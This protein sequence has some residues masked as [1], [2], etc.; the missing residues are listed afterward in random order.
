[1]NL[2]FMLAA[3]AA[4]NRPI[5]IGMIG[6]GKFGTMFLS[7]V[8]STVGMHLTGLADLMPDRA[9]ERMEIAGFALERCEASSLDDAL[10][11]GATYV[12]D[13]Q[14]A[15][16]NH[17][18]IEVIIEATGDPANG[19]RIANA[20]IDAGK[21]IVMVNVE[22]DALA[23]PLLARRAR[24]AGVVYSL[25]WGDQPAL[26]CEHIDWARTCGF[27]VVAAGKGTRYHP[28]YHTSTP[29]TVWDVLAKYMKIEQRSHIN[30]K[31]FNSFIDGTKSGIEMT[32]V[33]NAMG[34]VPQT[35]G[36]GFPP[37]SRFEVAEVC[38]PRADGG[39]LEKAG[40]TEVISSITREDTEVPHNLVMGTYVVITS[41]SAYSQTCFREYNCLPDTTGKYAALYRPTHMI[42]LELGLSVASAVLRGEPTGAPR[43]FNSDVVATA[44]RPL[45]AT[46]ILDGEGGFCVWGKQQSA[47]VSLREGYLPLGLAHDVK[48]KRDLPEGAMVRWDDVE[49]D[50]TADAVRFRREMEAAFG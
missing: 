29:E 12:T 7:Q 27:E 5:R 38:K 28:T 1:M 34:L 40:V 41:D 42:G 8:H 39:T 26:I 32:A 9:R 18:E 2:S 23:G 44:K 20:A 14:M 35:N 43:V 30:P 6:A 31:M 4:E 22:A 48:L 36:L 50:R 33:C 37:S 13:D 21:H 24:E 45:K 15:L 10:K 17:P 3:R 16:A 46:E 49:I 19:I 25:A 11:T 47:E